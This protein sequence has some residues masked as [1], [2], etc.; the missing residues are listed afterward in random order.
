MGCH[1]FFSYFCLYQ[2]LEYVIK[3]FELLK[4]KN[5]NQADQA[6]AG[7]RLKDIV[8]QADK[9]KKEVQDKFTQIQGSTE[10]FVVSLLNDHHDSYSSNR[11]SS[12]TMCNSTE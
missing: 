12:S 5:T 10:S 9:M 1:S 2:E 3:V 4:Q 8:E 7:K 6:E 11:R